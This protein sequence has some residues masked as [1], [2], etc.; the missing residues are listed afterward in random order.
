MQEPSKGPPNPQNL[1]P[2]LPKTI[3]DFYKVDRRSKKEIAKDEKEFRPPTA[4]EK[5]ESDKYRLT[6]IDKWETT[7]KKTLRS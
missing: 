5:V 2:Y 3:H 6:L 1:P 7:C 4:K